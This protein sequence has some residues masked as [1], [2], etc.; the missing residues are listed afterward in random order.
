MLADDIYNCNNT[1]HLLSHPPTSMC[2]Q[3]LSSHDMPYGS[4]QTMQGL[5][6]VACFLAYLGQWHHLARHVNHMHTRPPCEQSLRQQ[7]PC[8]S[9]QVGPV[10]HLQDVQGDST[11]LACML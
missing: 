8:C 4:A 2:R 5:S 3:Q 11:G 1:R 7:L 6:A 9:S 10:T